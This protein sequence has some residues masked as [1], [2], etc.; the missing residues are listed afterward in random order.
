MNLW[1]FCEELASREAGVCPTALYANVF[2]GTS[3][4]SGVAVTSVTMTARLPSNFL[5]LPLMVE[6]DSRN[7]NAGLE[8]LCNGF[9]QNIN[10]PGLLQIRDTFRQFVGMQSVPAGNDD[11]NNRP[12]GSNH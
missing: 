6:S 3:P 2:I 5:G 9:D 7:R 8:H 10:V 12:P 11:W 1:I 4:E